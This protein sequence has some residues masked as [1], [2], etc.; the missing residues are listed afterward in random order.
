MSDEQLKF[1]LEAANADTILQGKLKGAAD[2]QAVVGIAK[3]AGFVISV[4][5]I[6]AISQVKA[7][8]DEELTDVAGGNSW[9]AGSPKWSDKAFMNF[10]DG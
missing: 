7:L 2:P 10:Y 6:A 5:A 1:F 8:S 4:E 3:E 9:G